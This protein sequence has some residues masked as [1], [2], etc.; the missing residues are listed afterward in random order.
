MSII[1]TMRKIALLITCFM[2]FITSAFANNTFSFQF[3]E[4][5]YI[6]DNASV[7]RE[8]DAKKIAYWLKYLEA[9]KKV[10]IILVTLDSLKGATA[11]QVAHYA[12]EYSNP[13]KKDSTMIFLVA[14]YENK[15]GIE[16][17]ENIKSEI[18]YLT[19]SRI[20]TEE[21]YPQFKS[22]EYSQAL[23]N[24]IFSVSRTIEPSLIF[25]KDINLEKDAQNIVVN[26]NEKPS[27]SIK[28]F[29]TITTILFAILML[30]YFALRTIDG[31]KSIK[32]YRRCGFGIKF[33]EVI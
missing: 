3:D 5:G 18:S 11:S 28:K 29:Y 33:G 8:T 6:S 19:I 15:F 13:D 14:P 23:K 1:I 20:I 4:S 21:I 10:S 32:I 30:A 31:R 2:L 25:I 24:G 9:H 27:F 17:G 26:N 12:L 7:L 22:G 16:M